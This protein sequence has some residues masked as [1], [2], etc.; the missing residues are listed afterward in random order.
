MSPASNHGGERP[1]RLIVTA[2]IGRSWNP[3]GEASA[4]HWAQRVG[5]ELYIRNDPY[6]IDGET[7]HPWFIKW[8]I[9]ADAVEA[10][11]P[12]EVVWLDDDIVI[13][14]DADWPEYEAWAA[15]EV[16][17]GRDLGNCAQNNGALAASRLTDTPWRCEDGYYNTGLV[18]RRNPSAAEFRELGALARR[19]PLD[20][21][22]DQAAL[23]VHL[24]RRPGVRRLPLIWHVR[25]PDAPDGY[26]P[27]YINHF[28][29]GKWEKMNRLGPL[30]TKVPKG[31]ADEPATGDG[32]PWRRVVGQCIQLALDAIEL[33]DPDLA[34]AVLSAARERLQ[35]STAVL[36]APG[37]PETLH[38]LARKQRTDKWEWHHCFHGESYLDIYERY[39]TPLRHAPIKLLELGVAAGGSLR[40]WKEYFPHADIHG[41]DINPECQAHAE[42]RITVHTLSQGDAE[43][44][45][46]LARSVGGFDL[47]IDDASHINQLTIA[48]FDALFPHLR[49]GGYYIMEDLG[50]SYVE[51]AEIEDKER[52]MDGSLLTNADLGA[53]INQTRESMTRFF[54]A[55]LA[56]LDRARGEIRFIHF[57]SKVAVMRKVSEPVPD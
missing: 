10:R 8:D 28:L 30:W 11:A 37:T 20:L 22:P 27:G 26:L 56:D 40:M 43:G 39:L 15:F 53:D 45:A 6:V 23:A 54:A 47:I 5:A 41:I 51:Y 18:F 36:P 3:H 44:L 34:K 14:A 4:R 13:R 33:D 25:G 42:A 50:M 32:D 19:I 17:E 9:L 35:D 7:R 2:S 52:F 16:A 55:K 49:P 24:A 48:A 1:R 29:G 46:E 12:E 57:W 31:D 21:I 38:Q